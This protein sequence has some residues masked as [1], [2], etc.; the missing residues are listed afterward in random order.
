ML[1]QKCGLQ[2]AT[3]HLET[4]VFRQKVEEHLCG[5]CAGIRSGETNRRDART[6]DHANAVSGG[7]GELSDQAMTPGLQLKILQLLRLSKQQGHLTFADIEAVLPDSVDAHGEVNFVLAALQALEIDVIDSDPAATLISFPVDSAHGTTDQLNPVQAWLQQMSR[8]RPLSSA[9][10]TA[11]FQRVKRAEMRAEA[12]AVTLPAIAGY[13]IEVGTKLLV[14]EEPPPRVVKSAALKPTVAYL[15]AL[16]ALIS[17][18]R[19]HETR[20]R[21]SWE[22]HRQALTAKKRKTARAQLRRHQSL[23]RSALPRFRFKLKVLEEYLARLQSTLDEIN[24]LLAQV[25]S[26]SPAR[27]KNPAHAEVSAATTRLREI[28]HEQRISPALLASTTRKV[29]EQVIKAHAAKTK[30]VQAHLRQVLSIAKGHVNQGRPFLELIQE[31]NLGLMQAI[32]D[33]D[34]RRG[35]NFTAFAEQR[36]RQSIARGR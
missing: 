22:D 28:E 12:I 36:I 18:V 9:R 25:A 10:E 11:L 34:H 24:R 17:T 7:A 4:L 19:L 2:D 33:F 35:Q 20:V 27:R 26:E 23:L 8:I 21:K 5:L 29:A 31:G 6:G 15:K 30:L 1:C 14:K 32:E 16:P 3:V 13:F